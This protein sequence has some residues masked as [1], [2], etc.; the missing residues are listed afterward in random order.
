MIM[1]LVIGFLVFMGILLF[2]SISVF[3]YQTKDYKE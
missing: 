2:G 1:F 3:I